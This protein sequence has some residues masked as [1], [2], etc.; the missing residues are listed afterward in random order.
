[1]PRRL[2]SLSLVVLLGGLAAGCADDIAPAVRVGDTAEIS[3]DELLAEVAEWSGSPTL[4][5]QLGV[6]ST[7]GAG[8]GSYDTDFVDFVLTTRVSF[9]LHN[10][11]F[12]E[13]GLE[14]SDEDLARQRD[15]LLGD[16]AASAAVLGELSPAYAERL[17]ADAA[18][19]AAVRDAMGDGYSAW[20]VEVFTGADI[21]VDARYGRWDPQS[22][23]VV[24]PS[25]PLP[26]PSDPLGET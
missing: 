22:G 24:P 1:M 4:I 9:E 7:E 14:L 17:V 13:L 21:E 23:S 19:Q 16:P 6:T 15:A 8:A 12:R 3:D 26:A 2:R 5:T 25:G 10:A 18:R 20:Q 11:Q